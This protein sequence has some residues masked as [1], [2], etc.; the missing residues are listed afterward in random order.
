MT[1]VIGSSASFA[2]WQP[3]RHEPLVDEVWDPERARVEIRTIAA[4][5]VEAVRADGSWPRHPLDSDAPEP[6]RSLYWGAAGTLWALTH[7]A[8]AGELDALPPL[9]EWG[10]KLAAQYAATPDGGADSAS[11]FVG[12]CGVLL[13]AFRASRD[14]RLGEELLARAAGHL[15][16]PAREL[17]L[18]AAGAM[19]ACAFAWELTGDERFR[20]GYR[21]A[22]AA[23]LR[24][25]QAD[26]DGDPELW[27]QDLYGARRRLL[28]A[29][30]GLAGNLHALF[31]GFELLDA[32]TRSAIAE[33]AA[34][35]VVATARRAR[36][37]ANWPVAPGGTTF[38]VHW[39]HG[40]PGIVTAL[41][42]APRHAV[43]DEVLVE[44]GELV[45]RAGPL[46]KGPTLC[47]GT[48]GNG[49][50][51]LALFARTGDEKWLG[52][53]RRFA[54]HAAWQVRSAHER[55]GRGRY[56]LWTGDLGVAVYLRQCITAQPGLPALDF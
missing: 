48:A 56:G 54:M 7:L 43:L 39:C 47:H 2:L 34:R 4:E 16:H 44:A 50:A 12:A 36:G 13:A 10:M 9:A 25:W 45:W 51:L 31:R 30:H 14:P 38:L 53:A 35:S 33:R 40:A 52:R 27:T 6:A 20:D 1:A 46:R 28:G 55:F 24:E 11:Y 15:D 23:L 3:H 41:A 26:R 29:S 22:A 8:E 42:R 37:L 17:F 5:A 32:A 19:V 18:G 21:A 49:E